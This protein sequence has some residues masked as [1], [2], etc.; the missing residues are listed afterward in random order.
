MRKPIVWLTI[1]SKE[2]IPLVKSVIV[3]Q[4][5][6]EKLFKV[7]CPFKHSSVMRKRICGWGPKSLHLTT[8]STALFCHETCCPCW[9]YWTSFK[10]RVLFSSFSAWDNWNAPLLSGHIFKRHKLDKSESRDIIFLWVALTISLC[11]RIL[12]SFSVYFKRLL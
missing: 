10:N 5:E 3:V 8:P 9:L 6:T 1:N 12:M 2:W 7:F 11:S 4:K